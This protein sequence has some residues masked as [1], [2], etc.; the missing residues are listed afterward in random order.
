MGGRFLVTEKKEKK[1]KRGRSG[2]D[3]EETFFVGKHLYIGTHPKGC[4]M[5]HKESEVSYK[6]YNEKVNTSYYLL[7]CTGYWQFEV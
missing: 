4:M 6:R 5:Y 7:M 3:L 2:L 1:T